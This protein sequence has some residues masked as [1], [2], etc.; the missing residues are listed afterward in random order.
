MTALW[1][2]GAI[3]ER[4]PYASTGIKDKI[5]APFLTQALNRNSLKWESIHEKIKNATL[6]TIPI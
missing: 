2:E 6:A 4:R 3:P 1:V 5:A